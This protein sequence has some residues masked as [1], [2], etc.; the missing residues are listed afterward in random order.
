MKKRLLLIGLLATSLSMMAQ[1][2]FNFGFET[3]SSDLTV[4][5]LEFVNFMAKDSMNNMSTLNAHSGTNS[6]WLKNTDSIAGANYQRALKFR[7]LPVEP[8]TSYRV[9]FWVKG[10]N[11]YTLAGATSTSTANIRA[12]MSVG[13]ENHDVPFVGAANTAFDYNFTGFDPANWVKKTAVFYYANDAA[14]NAYYK[15]LNPDSADF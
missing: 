4:G 14:Q 15:F 9:S 7:A 13:T 1:E 5:K 3:P 2:I 11:T 6:L 12:R 8:N 10:N